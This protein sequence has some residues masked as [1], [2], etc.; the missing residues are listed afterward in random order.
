MIHGIV[1]RQRSSPTG[2]P[3]SLVLGMFAC[4]T[5]ELPWH[6]NKKGVSCIVADSYRGRVWFSPTMNRNVIRLEDKHG[7]ADCLIHAGNFAADQIDLDG[8]G[9]PE[10][11]QVHGCTEV[12]R[13]YGDIL[14]KDGKTQW[15]IKSSGVTLVALIELL[16][17]PLE[18]SGYHEVEITYTWDK[19]CEP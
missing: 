16:A 14:R 17:D 10:I 13:G 15:G 7:R 12:G 2:T 6:D 1:V 5:L 9:A 18:P 8:D 19:G 4:N 11:T 3:G